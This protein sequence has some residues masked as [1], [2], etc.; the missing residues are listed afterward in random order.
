MQADKDKS[1]TSVSTLNKYLLSLLGS[2]A[3]I[4][5]WW[6]SPNLSFSNL[7]PIDMYELH[8]EGKVAVAQYILKCYWSDGS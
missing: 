6:T 4:E 3:L 5:Q 8:E 7:S 2:E 1:I